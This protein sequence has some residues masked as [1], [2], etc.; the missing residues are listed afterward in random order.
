MHAMT[1]AAAASTC[2]APAG[3]GEGG[4]TGYGDSRDYKYLLRRQHRDCACCC[5]GTGHWGSDHT[6]AY[7]CAHASCYYCLLMLCPCHGN[8]DR[9]RMRRGMRTHKAAVMCLM[10]R[11]HVPELHR[12]LGLDDLVTS[13]LTT[14]VTAPIHRL[15]THTWVPH[16]LL[17]LRLPNA[18]RGGN[19]T[20]IQSAHP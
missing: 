16:Q 10:C 4:G 12:T 18:L 8:R 13:Q 2:A 7:C 1:A 11:P 15:T 5:I 19:A 20:C 14:A 3:R 6:Q 17:V 9:G